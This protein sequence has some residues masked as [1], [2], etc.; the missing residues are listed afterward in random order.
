VIQFFIFQETK[1]LL[2]ADLVKEWMLYLNEESSSA[3]ALLS[4][5]E[6]VAQLEK[7]LK[8]LSSKK[9]SSKL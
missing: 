7:M 5:T 6:T 1:K 3:W 4:A 2:R 8:T 9:T